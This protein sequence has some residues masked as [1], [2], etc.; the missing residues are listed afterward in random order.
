[1]DLRCDVQIIGLAVLGLLTP[2]SIN[3]M[4]AQRI[5]AILAGRVPMG[6]QRRLL[7]V[8][9]AASLQFVGCAPAQDWPTR[10]VTMVIAFPAGGSTDIFG[11]I[12]APRLSE[13]LGQ[14]VIVENVVGSGTM[15]GAYR[16]AK[17][18]PD[19]YEFM[20][21]HL[22]THAQYQTIYKNPLYN[23]ATDFAPV[24]LLVEQ[25]QVLVTRRDL[26]ANDLSQFIAYAKANP[27]TMQY[28]SGGGAASPT[29]LNCVLLNMAIGVNVTHVP[30]SG[31][32]P[33]MQDLIAGRIDYMCAGLADVKPQVEGNRIKAIAILA[34]NRSPALPNVPSAH[35][36][37]LTDFETS[38]WFAL[39][40]PKG[41]PPAIVQKLNDA[42][43]T[44]M[45]T[46]SVQE[47]LKELGVTVVAP[48]RRSPEYLKNFVEGE[49]EKWAPTIRKA[50]VKAD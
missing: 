29:Y 46:A 9:L 20:I 14:Q 25:P 24:A 7:A 19:G 17:A 38:I 15:G 48:E 42:T 44:A 27:A 16:V 45:N 26:P 8:T 32:G 1:M 37:G 39:F 49:I 12:F 13:L 40:L 41:T 33:A 3:F 4:L 43:V 50:N 34:K 6:S 11:R 22:G 23:A 28:G 31:S 18:A 35:E 21:G 36:Q 47:R 30:S 5:A 2:Q 10:P